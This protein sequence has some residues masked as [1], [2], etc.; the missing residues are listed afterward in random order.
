MHIRYSDPTLN[1]RFYHFILILC[2]VTIRIFHTTYRS[3]VTLYVSYVVVVTTE[4]SN[5]EI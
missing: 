3:N 5:Q 4:R 1:L 2:T